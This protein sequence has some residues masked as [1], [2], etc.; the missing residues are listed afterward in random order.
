MKD[1]PSSQS[2]NVVVVGSALYLESKA[3]FAGTGPLFTF[4]AHCP[5]DCSLFMETNL[6]GSTLVNV[7][8]S[9]SFSPNTQQFGRT[10]MMSPNLGGNVMCL[11]TSFS[12]CIRERNT[13]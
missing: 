8:S 1:L 5:F 3:L 4:H 2:E 12:S 10:G 11:N 13:D 7:S 6:L 9:S